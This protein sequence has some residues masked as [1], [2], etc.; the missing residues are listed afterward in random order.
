MMGIDPIKVGI[1]ELK[2]AESPSKI[3]T[4]GLGS[5]IGVCLWDNVLKIG[6]MV[7]VMLPD[8]T[9]NRSILNKAKYADTGVLLLIEEMLKMGA[10]QSRLTAK[11]AG[12]SQ[13]FQ[14]PGSNNVMRIGERNTESVKKALKQEGIKILAED[15]GGNFGR[16]IEFSTQNG[17]L[18]VKTIHQGIK[19]I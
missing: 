1:A 17:D 9:Q 11:I 15:T 19:V 13:M 2:V 8:S 7:H 3:I 10:L 4:N 18:L 16:T 14:F 12:G 5:C 6:G